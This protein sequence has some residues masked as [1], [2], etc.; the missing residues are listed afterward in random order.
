MPNEKPILILKNSISNALLVFI[1]IAIFL[2]T[3]FISSTL[4]MQ[5]SLKSLLQHPPSSK[6]PRMSF[7]ISWHFTQHTNYGSS[8]NQN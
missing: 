3:Y 2:Y 4:D 6:Q 5:A 8:T 1:C 7:S